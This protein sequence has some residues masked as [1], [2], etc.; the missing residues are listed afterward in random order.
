MDTP[1]IVNIRIVLSDYFKLGMMIPVTVDYNFHSSKF[2]NIDLGHFRV[3]GTNAI[4]SHYLKDCNLSPM[5]PS[6]I[7][8]T[9]ISV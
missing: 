7:S 9:L 1:I 4:S 8:N 3:P 2:W 6:Q 5:S